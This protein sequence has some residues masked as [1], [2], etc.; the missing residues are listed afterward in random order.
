MPPIEFLRQFRIAEYAVF[1]F[2]ASFIGIY[3]LA[4]FLSKLFLKL[5]V[6]IPKRNW[7]FLTLPIGIVVHLLVGSITP[8]TRD[9]LD[10]G[11]HYI[12]KIFILVLLFFGLKG[13]K[14]IKKNKKYD[15]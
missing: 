15:S 4:P 13:I 12:L 2:V 9:F 11:G 3:L 1:D 8:M 10:L 5:R 14:I 6:D 7:L